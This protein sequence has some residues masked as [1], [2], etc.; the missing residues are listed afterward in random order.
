MLSDIYFRENPYDYGH[1]YERMGEL[2]E[3]MRKTAE[4]EDPQKAK[5]MRVKLAYEKMLQAIR[6]QGF[7]YRY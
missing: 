1:V 7:L 2:D 4:M 6:L 3:E 5:E